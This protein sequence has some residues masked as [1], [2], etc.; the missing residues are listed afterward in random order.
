[1]NSSTMHCFFQAFFIFYPKKKWE[2]HD[3]SPSFSMSTHIS[4]AAL[5][6]S[7]HQAVEFKNVKVVLFFSTVRVIKS[8]W[9][10]KSVC[11]RIRIHRFVFLVALLK[12]F[13]R[14][15]ILLFHSLVLHLIKIFLIK[16]V[17][18]CFFKILHFHVALF[19]R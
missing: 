6:H 4:R 3:D 11:S 5:F 18:F 15:I 16:C 12:H 9:R 1:M 17:F 10:K 19:T 8:S 14:F 2:K 7:I 13:F